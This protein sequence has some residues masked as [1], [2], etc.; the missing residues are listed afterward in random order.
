MAN[1]PRG[2]YHISDT[3]GKADSKMA[4]SGPGPVRGKSFGKV[5][6]GPKQGE[7]KAQAKVSWQKGKMDKRAE[8]DG[9]AN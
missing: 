8:G 4:G 2:G 7:Q 5:G 3:K 6:S 1:K 9:D